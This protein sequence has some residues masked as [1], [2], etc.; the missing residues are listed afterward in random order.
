MQGW[1]DSFLPLLKE[2]NTLKITPIGTSMF[3]LF[4][5]NNDQ[6]V[7]AAV[8]E[9]KL[10]RGHVILYRR[11]NGMLVL[12]R[13]AKK[14][15]DGFYMVGDNQTELEGPI[16]TEQIRAIMIA[17]YRKG[18][19]IS[20]QNFIYIVLSHLWLFLRPIRPMISRP[21]GILYRFF[22]SKSENNG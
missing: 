17:F 21:L 15:K 22:K 5:R 14:T 13:I 3:P 8:N 12:H 7:L 10:H 11:S 4:I 16:Y 19:F 2:G 6:A 9:K 20:C 18:H 1:S